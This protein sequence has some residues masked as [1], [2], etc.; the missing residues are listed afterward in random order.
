MKQLTKVTR[1]LQILRCSR[2]TSTMKVLALKTLT[3]RSCGRR[4]LRRQGLSAG[5]IRIS[6]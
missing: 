4:S 6:S 1:R 5:V 2:S 3:L